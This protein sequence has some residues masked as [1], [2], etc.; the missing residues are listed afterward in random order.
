MKKY[1]LA[2]V[3]V[4]SI[5][6]AQLAY[7]DVAPPQ[8]PQ[9]PQG[10]NAF[11]DVTSGSTY[12]NAVLY[13]KNQGVISGYP[14]GTFKPNNTINRAEFTKILVGA[15]PSYVNNGLCMETFAKPDS[16]GYYDLFT[17]VLSAGGAWYLEPI[18]YAKTNHFID[19]YSDGSFKPAQEINFAEAAKIIANAFQLTSS[20]TAASTPW[21]KVYVDALASKKAIPITITTFNQQ[22]TRGEMAEMAY[23]MK[24]QNT[25]LPS[26]TYTDLAS[27]GSTN[28]ISKDLGYTLTIPAA[29]NKYN[30]KVIYKYTLKSDPTNTDGVEKYEDIYTAD[31]SDWPNFELLRIGR[32]PAAIWNAEL[33]NYT[34]AMRV[35]PNADLTKPDFLQNK[36]G[37][38]GTGPNAYIYYSIVVRQDAPQQ[39]IADKDPMP[40]L[41]KDFKISGN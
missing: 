35:N 19:G 20:T 23:R 31:F 3:V 7:A 25:G 40:D 6:G 8:I 37:E 12:Y 22:I 24:S 15:S 18:C 39:F 2:G 26:K 4:L 34:E 27:A 36:I 11:S 38:S 21:Y 29:W 1:L 33:T 16:S 14:D 30:Y 9:T 5:F 32:M 17:D 10:T 13:L 41:T 28:Y